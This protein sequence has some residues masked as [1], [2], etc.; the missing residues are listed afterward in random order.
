MVSVVIA[1]HNEE[2]VLGSC[3]DALLD[4]RGSERMEIV[5]SANG[6]TDATVQVAAR[7]GVTVVDRSEPGKAGALNA[8]DEVAGSYPRIYLDADIVVPPGGIDA[9]LARLHAA[10]RPKAVVPRR[11]INTV[12]RPWPVKAYFS[13]NERL[14]V[15][16]NGLFGRGMI[17]VSAEGRA[18]FDEFP[19]MIADDLFIDSQYADAEKAEAVEVGVLVEAPY[20]TKD[21]LNRLVRVRRGNVQMRAA[22]AAGDLGID[23][24]SSD[25]WAWLRDVVAPNPQLA[26]AAIP[27]VVITVLASRLA[28][29][30]TPATASWGRD[31]STR[32]VTRASDLAQAA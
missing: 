11:N 5:V 14:P 8:A 19:T 13:I 30:G 4:Q 27:Y 23:V 21:L 28:R 32:N 29:R 17:A 12:G 7:R 22:S 31:E 1:A 6:C 10:D 16:R 3:L 20:T 18:R 15:F 25:K 2:A 26:F 24:R 9:V